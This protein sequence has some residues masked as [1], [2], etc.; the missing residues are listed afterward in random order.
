MKLDDF[1]N[2]YADREGVL[3][4]AVQRL[5]TGES[6]DV[7]ARD[8]DKYGISDAELDEASR[9][10]RA[11]IVAELAK[12]FESVGRTDEPQMLRYSISQDELEEATNKERAFRAWQRRRKTQ[13]RHLA[14]SE[15][16]GL[17]WH[18]R[19]G[20]ALQKLRI[21]EN[22]VVEL[23]NKWIA[24]GIF[25]NRVMRR[26]VEK[27]CRDPGWRETFSNALERN[28]IDLHIVEVEVAA[29]KELS[30]DRKTRS[31]DRKKLREDRTRS[32]NS[33][34]SA[35]SSIAAEQAIDVHNLPNPEPP[36][37]R[38]NLTPRMQSLVNSLMS[39]MDDKRMMEVLGR[40]YS[41]IDFQTAQKEAFERLTSGLYREE[42]F[43]V[44]SE[45]IFR[46]LSLE[47][48]IYLVAMRTNNLMMEDIIERLRKDLFDRIA[49]S[50]DF[51]SVEEGVHSQLDKETRLRKLIKYISPDVEGP[52]LISELRARA[53]RLLLRQILIIRPLPDNWTQKFETG[54][55]ECELTQEEVLMQLAKHETLS[56]FEIEQEFNDLPMRW[57]RPLPDRVQGGA[58]DQWVASWQ[59]IMDYLRDGWCQNHAE[60]GDIVIEADLAPG[61][62][63]S[64][65]VRDADL[66]DREPSVEN[67]HLLV[68]FVNEL[69]SQIDLEQLGVVY[70]PGSKTG[71][72]VH[73]M[74]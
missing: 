50:V 64:I 30:E 57:R 72:C 18:R 44:L 55:L 54:M 29:A 1:L 36:A 16:I 28:G 71:F 63:L 15:M 3:Q 31:E 4:Q 69:A 9:I 60:L 66:L 22:E 12:T 59:Y 6:I 70:I 56:P 5:L 67:H 34:R 41:K 49:R 46:G 68:D 45:R 58:R 51:K 11:S 2:Y 19:L 61:S 52:K 24:S 26:I 43:R 17:D 33:D 39:C 21:D 53:Q 35:E 7:H 20:S 27:A 32:G 13:L 74:P 14:E 65:T 42:V 38:S 73:P 62:C 37:Q 25:R 8:L 47:Q 23:A 40:S 48:Q 10:K